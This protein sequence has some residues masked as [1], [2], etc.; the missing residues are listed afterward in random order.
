MS[1]ISSSD[2]YES[3]SETDEDEFADAHDGD[4]V[5]GQ[6]RDIVAA[7][8]EIRTQLADQNK[9][10][11]VL[12]EKYLPPVT[13]QEFYVSEE[14][15]TESIQWQQEA[16]QRSRVPDLQRVRDVKEE[17]SAGLGGFIDDCDVYFYTHL[18]LGC[19]H[20][21]LGCTAGRPVPPTLIQRDS[22]DSLLSEWPI[23]PDIPNSPPRIYYE[24][25]N[26]WSDY[27]WFYACPLRPGSDDLTQLN[28]HPPHPIEMIG[29][30]YDD[31]A[32]PEFGTYAKTDNDSL[33]KNDYIK[34]TSYMD[35]EPW[36]GLIFG[37]VITISLED[38]AVIPLS[39]IAFLSWQLS[40]RSKTASTDSLRDENIGVSLILN[41]TSPWSRVHL[42]HVSPTSDMCLQFQ[43]RW[44]EVSKTTKAR[45]NLYTGLH[46]QRDE[47]DI[48]NPD[49]TTNS[50][51]LRE[52]RN[53]FG[54]RTTTYCDLPLYT[55]V[56]ISDGQ[57]IEY[58]LDPRFLERYMGKIEHGPYHAGKLMG[59][60]IF[61]V[62]LSASLDSMVDQWSDSLDQLDATLDINL[63][64]ISRIKR[65]K[66]MLDDDQS[67]RS[68]Q[69]F[70]A[71]Q[72]LYICA[73]WIKETTRGVKTLCQETRDC[74]SS[75]ELDVCDDHH[76][77][78][79]IILSA[80]ICDIEAKFQPLL[81]RIKREIA[82]VKVLRDG[83]LHATSARQVSK[84]TNLARNGQSRYI[85]A[86][87][88]TVAAMLYLSMGFVTTP[89]GNRPA[90]QTTPIMRSVIVSLIAYLT[91]AYA[92]W[93]VHDGCWIREIFR[94]WA[95]WSDATSQGAR[96][97]VSI[98]LKR[99]KGKGG[100]V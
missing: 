8:T 14:D 63:T 9:Y 84:R 72:V 97:R 51:H 89:F 6:I 38:M 49:E 99:G 80:V 81:D 50:L 53:A 91:A 69:Y 41:F 44:M 66:T 85:Y 32:H 70:A 34:D 47:G 23:H 37:E 82:E 74:L 2:I 39:T 35:G 19:S 58:Q 46:L 4:G 77:A 13:V 75:P 68:D 1:Q 11:D 18:I 17:F 71:L 62:V 96:Y 61:F 59:I 27:D 79:N 40:S 20:P 21:T 57:S 83:L 15:W 76:K 93:F 30:G 5:V 67:S 12:A 65:Q 26:A 16:W 73:D 86:M 98:L 48:P 100:D 87:V 24:Q 42:A 94:L 33:M 25:D 55:I 36:R 88:F 31:D 54:I 90:S 92:L 43:M 95:F 60:A 10:L 78:L 56:R 52:M 45:D 29:M 22:L 28:C 7:L 64:Q 3:S